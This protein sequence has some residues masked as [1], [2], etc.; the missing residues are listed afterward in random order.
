MRLR[1]QL[2]PDPPFFSLCT[3]T[4]LGQ[5]KVDIACV[6]LV[7]KGPNLMD[8]P[9]ISHFVQSSVNAAM[10]EYVAPKSLTLDL[11][12]MMMGDDF[13]KDTNARGVI[14]VTIKH[15]FDF[16]EGD[17]SWGPL[18]KGSADPYVAVGWAKFGKPLWST[19]VLQKNMEPHWEETCY[20]LVSPEEVDVD[21]RL[22]LQLFDSDRTSADDDLGRIEIDLKQLMTDKAT[23]GRMEDRKDGFKSLKK[24]DSMPGKL[25]WSVGYFSKTRITAEQLTA[26][27]EDPNI[28]TL[29]QLK[30]KVYKESEK[31][32]REAGTDEKDE[33][34]QQ[35][36]QDLKVSD[37]T[38]G[39]WRRL[40]TVRTGT[41]R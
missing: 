11:K 20:V 14:I 21:E 8:L 5:P 25:S 28:K 36:V 24:G 41:R 10:A 9:L 22:R 4:F 2:T 38:P 31:K 19:R 39:F 37:R 32:L 23:N 12:D 6:P 3:L 7:K 17:A 30:E 29:D 13:K 33:V 27:E 18:K 35:K 16:K 15:A 40:L 26:Q 1:L 34:E